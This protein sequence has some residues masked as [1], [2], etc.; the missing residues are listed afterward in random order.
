[1]F[2]HAS[3]RLAASTIAPA[4]SDASKCRSEACGR[5]KLLR[6]PLEAEDLF[7]ASDLILHFYE[8]IDHRKSFRAVSCIALAALRMRWFAPDHHADVGV[9]ERTSV[10]VL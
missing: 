2:S 9:S 5:G 6:R 7:H 3:P 10:G 1:M 4:L 8:A